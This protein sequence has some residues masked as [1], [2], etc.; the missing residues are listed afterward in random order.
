MVIASLKNLILEFGDR[1]VI[2]GVNVLCEE[3]AVIGLIGGN[4]AGKSTLLNVLMGKLEPTA[5]ERF[6][7]PNVRMGYLRQNSG[8]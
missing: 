1:R 3:G 4:G 2:D 7:H 5:G 6:I 8:L